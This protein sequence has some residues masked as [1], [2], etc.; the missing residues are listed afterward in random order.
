MQQSKCGCP[1]C[2]RQ[3]VPVTHNDWKNRKNKNGRGF[4]THVK[5]MKHIKPKVVK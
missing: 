1:D 3:P 2:K 4:G 5:N